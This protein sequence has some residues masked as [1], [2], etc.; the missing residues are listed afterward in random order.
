MEGRGRGVIE[1]ISWHLL[2]GTE[3]YQETPQSGGRFTA[4]YRTMPN[5]TQLLP[6]Y[7]IIRMALEETGVEGKGWIQLLQDRVQRGSFVNTVITFKVIKKQGIYW[8][9]GREYQCWRHV[10]CL[11]QM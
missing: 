8:P 4:D 7:T 10:T 1:I 2:G 3:E 11:L 6:H 5:P 9:T